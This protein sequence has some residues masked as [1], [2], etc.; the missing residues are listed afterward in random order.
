MPFI[1]AYDH[2]PYIYIYIYTGSLVTAEVY[3]VTISVVLKAVSR[4]SNF[5]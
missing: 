3:G 5:I 1:V 2:D 4:K